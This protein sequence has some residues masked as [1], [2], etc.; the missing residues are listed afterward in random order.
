MKKI[1]F[2]TMVLTSLF[3]YSQSCSFGTVST[4]TGNFGNMSTGG[5]YEYNNATDFDI[6]F[7]TVFNVEQIK[8]NMLKGNA[9]LEFV[10]IKI[11]KDTEGLPGEVLHGFMELTP[12][13]QEFVNEVDIENSDLYQ[14]TIDLPSAVQLGKGKYYLQINAKAGDANGAWWEITTESVQT[15]G[16]FD[17]SQFHTDPWFTGFSYYDHVFEI[18]GTCTDTG[19][20]QPDYGVFCEQG[21]GS[22]AHE[23]GLSLGGF[24][25]A[26]DFIV[27]ENSTFT[28]SGFKMSTLQ[29][30][31][32][33]NANI[34]IRKQENGKP[35]EVIFEAL[36][37][38]PRTENFYGYWPLEVY[39]LDVV[40]IDLEFDFEEPITL[41]SGTYYLE[42]KATA[43]PFTDIL[44]WE[45]TSEP[46]IGGNVFWSV[47]DG[48]NWTEHEGYNLVF[49]VRGFCNSTLNVDDV[50]K[51]NVQFY[52]NP[53]S[54]ELNIS[55]KEAV[56]LFSVYNVSSQ[57]V[58]AIKGESKKINTSSLTSGIYMLKVEFQNGQVDTFKI[59]KK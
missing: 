23:T 54:D 16:R 38:G 5:D 15:L 42:V 50:E 14:I 13:Q 34:K 30:G 9:D 1:L 59:I 6:A 21:N 39:P 11:L 29:L 44:T 2:T 43:T 49:D 52:P 12:S 7:G 22:N 51:M 47:D 18:L 55:T 26:D 57:K 45:A 41:E 3:A 17:P 32:I 48:E 31:N 20:E 35:G 8:F 46:G 10:N 58:M 24:N 33:V 19:E 56:K 37:I 40:A 53:V 36:K 25:L 27:P 4:N 28:L